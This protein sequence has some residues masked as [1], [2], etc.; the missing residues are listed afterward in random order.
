M[1]YLKS[2]SYREIMKMPKFLTKNALFLYFWPR[3]LKNYCHIW[4]Q[5]PQ[6]C[7]FAKYHAIM[8]MPK[9]GTEN[10][11]FGYFW[12]RILKN[13]CNIWNLHPQIC[14]I[15]IFN[16]YSEFWCRVLFF[17][18]CGFHFCRRSGSK[19]GTALQNMPW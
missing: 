15:W 4:N 9:F 13:Y 6:I 19:S 18:R 8:K 1:S 5:H 3:I 11:L 12:A 10:T 7:L 14:Q 17:Q 2:A 16:L